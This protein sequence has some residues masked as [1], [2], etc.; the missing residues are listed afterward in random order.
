MIANL[1]LSEAEMTELVERV[2]AVV[3]ERMG[4]PSAPSPYMSIGEAAEYL[5]ARRQRVYDLVSAGRLTRFKDG[6]RVL[7]SRAELD[8]YLSGVAHRLPTARQRRTAR[9]SST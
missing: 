1:K 3:L 7:V 8:A 5:R 9:G 2:A 6:S 4:E